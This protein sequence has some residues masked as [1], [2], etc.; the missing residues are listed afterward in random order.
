MAANKQANAAIIQAMAHYGKT[1]AETSKLNQET[2]E[3][4]D[5]TGPKYDLWYTK[6]GITLNHLDLM[7]QTP[8]AAARKGP[9]PRLEKSP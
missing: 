9:S 8:R 4:A 5:L 3:K 6:N 7:A 1:S 2:R